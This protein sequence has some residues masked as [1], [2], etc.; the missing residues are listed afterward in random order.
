MTM[1]FICNDCCNNLS[2]DLITVFSSI[3]KRNLKIKYENIVLQIDKKEISSMRGRIRMKE[4]NKIISPIYYGEKKDF[5][6]EFSVVDFIEIQID[7]QYYY[8][9]SRQLNVEYLNHYYMAIAVSFH[10]LN[11][12][13][14]LRLSLVPAIEKFN[15]EVCNI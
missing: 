7:F 14:S 11:D 13:E 15:N 10:F 4:K 2:M 3:I 1:I 5:S 12:L 6:T 8:F 9:I